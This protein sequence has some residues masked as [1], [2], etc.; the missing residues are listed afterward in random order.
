MRRRFI[1]EESAKPNPFTKR[2]VLCDVAMGLC[3]WWF[4]EKD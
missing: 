1:E 2:K 4:T 3:L